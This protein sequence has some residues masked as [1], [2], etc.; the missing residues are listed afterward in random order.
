MIDRLHVICQK[1]WET[2][3][4]PTQWTQS[5]MITVPK[6]DNLQQC[7]NYCTISLICHPSK[8][9]VRIILN[10]LRPQAEEIIAEE[11]AGFRTG[12]S[13]TEQIFNLRILCERYLQHQQD[14]YHVFVDFK[15]AFDRVWHA[16]LWATLNHYNMNAYTIRVIRNLYN[17]TS[18]TVYLNRNFGE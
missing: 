12:R 8:V 14:L 1:I 11:Q 17:Q 10:R 15:K 6:K 4:W 16:A 5:L 9:M 13:T 18:S 2:G 3:R 7:D